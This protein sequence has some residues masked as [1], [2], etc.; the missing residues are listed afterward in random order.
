MGYDLI[1]GKFSATRKHFWRGLEFIGDYVQDGDKVLDFGCGNG[2]L[3]E[4]FEGKQIEYIGV[5]VS[6]KLIEIAKNKYPSD[7]ISFQKIT[8]QASLAFPDNY[9]NSVYSIAVL[10]H[11]PSKEYREKMA[12]ELFRVL[13]PSGRVVITVWNLYQKKYLKNLL[14][15]WLGKLFGRSDLDWNDCY[16]SFTDNQGQVFPRFHH[17]FIKRELRRLFEE[18]GFEVEKCELSDGRNWVLVGRKLP[19]RENVVK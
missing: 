6:E 16:V 5:D 18:A 12:E 4:L 14:S 8:G 10:H 7:G 17:A 1:S 3:L 13:A 15:N 19:S 2:R 11:F 9:F